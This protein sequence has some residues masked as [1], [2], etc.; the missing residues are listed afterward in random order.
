MF[1]HIKKIYL[2][3]SSCLRVGVFLL[4]TRKVGFCLVQAS[5]HQ[6]CKLLARQSTELTVN[7]Q[8]ATCCKLRENPNWATY[9]H[10]AICMSK[11]CS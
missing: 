8:E 9:S 11:E 7:R 6:I 3:L 2:S 1:A 4:L 10:C 5:L